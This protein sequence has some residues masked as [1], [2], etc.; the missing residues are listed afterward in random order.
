[1][2]QQLRKQIKAKMFSVSSL[3]KKQAAQKILH[4]LLAYLQQHN[5]NAAVIAGYIPMPHELDILP[6]LYELERNG[7]SICLPRTPS[8]LLPLE[9]YHYKMGDDLISNPFWPKLQE[10]PLHSQKTLPSLIITPLVAFDV[11][12]NRLGQGKGF[13]DCTFANLQMHGILTHKIGLAME[14]QRVERIIEQEHDVCLDA[15]ITEASLYGF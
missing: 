10:P 7:F 14:L 12:L 3:Q 11:K 5:L 9:F 4:L 6:I 2:R 15:V 1:M 8:I 13:Y